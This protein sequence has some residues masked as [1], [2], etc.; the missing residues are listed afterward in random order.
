VDTAP[1]VDLVADRL[2][3]PPDRAW[4]PLPAHAARRTRTLA[5][6]L[7]AHG[8]AWRIAQSALFLGEIE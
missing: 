3:G 6:G 2:G 8:R 1:S 5:A 4:E 7:A